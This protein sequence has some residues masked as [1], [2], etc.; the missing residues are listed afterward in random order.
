M[1]PPTAGLDDP[2]ILILK[3]VR[4]HHGE[5]YVQSTEEV[6]RPSPFIGLQTT[7]LNELFMIFYHS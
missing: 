7:I 4:G 6:L 2:E 1:A 5:A 3:L